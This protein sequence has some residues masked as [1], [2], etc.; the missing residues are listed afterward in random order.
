M[1]TLE[2]FIV[3]LKPPF[4][5]FVLVHKMSKSYGYVWEHLH[6]SLCLFYKIPMPLPCLLNKIIL[7]KN[8]YIMKSSTLLLMIMWSFSSVLLVSLRNAIW[9]DKPEAG[10]STHPHIALWTYKF[11]PGFLV[12]LGTHVIQCFFPSLGHCSLFCISG[13]FGWLVEGAGLLCL[14]VWGQGTLLPSSIRSLPKQVWNSWGII[15]S[16]EVRRKKL[17]RIE[18]LKRQ[19]TIFHPFPDTSANG[20]A[21]HYV[22]ILIHIPLCLL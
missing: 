12:L 17:L 13:W 20:I 7:L 6:F 5:L 19:E 21:V 18:R 10:M 22:V 3:L 9:H 16:H 2:K 1:W 15:W 14:V 8:Q 11:C 4:V